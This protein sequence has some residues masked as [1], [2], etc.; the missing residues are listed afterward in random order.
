MEKYTVTYVKGI[1]LYKWN[2]VCFA[3]FVWRD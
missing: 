3:V 1:E 2:I